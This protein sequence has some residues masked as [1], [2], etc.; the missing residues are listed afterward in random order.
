MKVIAQKIVNL[1]KM[2]LCTVKYHCPS[3]FGCLSWSVRLVNFFKM[4]LV[5]LVGPV[6]LHKPFSHHWEWNLKECPFSELLK[7]IL[8]T[9][10]EG[11]VNYT[12]G[13]MSR[14]VYIHI[15]TLFFV[16]QVQRV[17]CFSSWDGQLYVEFLFITAN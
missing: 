1:V 2:Y 11:F 13:K 3:N 8:G 9:S 17:E 10:R 16:Q 15:K 6:S 12:F 14:H 5:V 7:K 4:F